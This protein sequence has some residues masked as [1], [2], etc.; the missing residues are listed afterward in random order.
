MNLFVC[1]Q[2]H[3][4]VFEITLVF[5]FF[6]LSEEGGGRGSVREKEKEKRK[7]GSIENWEVD[8]WVVKGGEREKEGKLILLLLL[9]LLLPSA[10]SS[11][12]GSLLIQRGGRGH[13][14]LI[15]C[16][17]SILLHRV[18]YYYPNHSIHF[19]YLPPK[20]P[21][22]PSFFLSVSLFFRK[23]FL[24]PKKKCLTLID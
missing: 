12:R 21:Y 15:K 24:F 17:S 6:W 19:L 14:P 1:A 7:K 23:L 18:S 22:M 9:L 3:K 8:R 11:L 4:K 20:H 13:P 2:R 10:H 16:Q 5:F